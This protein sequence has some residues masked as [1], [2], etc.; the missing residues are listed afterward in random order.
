MSPKRPER[1]APSSPKTRSGSVAPT[2]REGS[3]KLFISGLM[4][5]PAQN[6]RDPKSKR[7][8]RWGDPSVLKPVRVVRLLSSSRSSSGR[9][10]S[11]V[12]SRSSFG[13]SSSS[14]VGSGSGVSRSSFSRSGF[15]SRS[16]SSRGFFGRLLASGDGQSGDSGASDEQF[17]QNF[18]G[19]GSRSLQNV[20]TLGWPAPRVSN[21]TFWVSLAR[22][23]F[24]DS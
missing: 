24:T 4:P 13:R 9:S 11:S 6:K 10:G 15:S 2:G 23:D 17:A 8:A 3:G 19:H 20:R 1:G 7:A 5:E 18:R 12:S 22:G 16:F 21:R 14:S